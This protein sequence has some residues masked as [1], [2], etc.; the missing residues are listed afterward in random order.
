MTHLTQILKFVGIILYIFHC[1][2]QKCS[3]Y[4]CLFS[5]FYFFYFFKNNFNFIFF[6]VPTISFYFKEHIVFF[7]C[8]FL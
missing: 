2:F 4:L 7:D 1:I 5:H 8:T 3:L 6:F